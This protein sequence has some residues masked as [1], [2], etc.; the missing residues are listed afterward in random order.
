MY[1]SAKRKQVLN[2]VQ[3][4]QSNTLPTVERYCLPGIPMLFLSVKLG[5]A[6]A[7]IQIVA[8]AILPAEI[9]QEYLV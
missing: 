7:Q 9:I 2:S 5:N 4:I 3:D 8:Q 1:N 6:R